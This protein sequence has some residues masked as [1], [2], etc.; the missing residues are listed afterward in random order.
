MKGYIKEFLKAVYPRCTE[1][2]TAFGSEEKCL[3]D[4]TARINYLIS[5]LDQTETCRTCTARIASEYQVSCH[6]CG[7][8]MRVKNA[9]EGL[10]V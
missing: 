5:A 7:V 1:L 8:G 10:E 6:E 2:A 3:K 4:A 9:I